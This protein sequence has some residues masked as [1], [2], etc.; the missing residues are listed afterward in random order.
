MRRI[1]PIPAHSYG[2]DFRQLEDAESQIAALNRVKSQLAMQM[3]ELRRQM[4]Q[5]S[6][7]RQNFQSQ[8]SLGT[9]KGTVLCLKARLKQNDKIKLKYED[10]IL[11]Q[12]KHRRCMRRCRTRSML[13]LRIGQE[14]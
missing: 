11:A 10:G 7:E 6:R 5:E 8:V 2:F 3:E 14:R 9:K 4:E 1:K 12:A 13:R